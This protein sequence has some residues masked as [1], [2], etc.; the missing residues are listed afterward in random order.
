M[1]FANSN[2]ESQR[3]SGL[4]RF[5]Q[6]SSLDGKSVGRFREVLDC[7]SPLP[8]WGAGAAVNERQRA[9]AVQDAGAR[10]DGLSL[11]GGHGIFENVL[12]PRVV[13]LNPVGIAETDENLA[14]LSSF[15]AV[16]SPAPFPK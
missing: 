14:R 13:C 8:L 2:N 10:F 12:K 7:G 11:F 16:T 9:A 1:T 3:D 15:P 6:S 5:N 4:K